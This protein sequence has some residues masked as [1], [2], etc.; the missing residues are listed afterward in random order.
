MNDCVISDDMGDDLLTCSSDTSRLE[1]DGYDQDLEEPT[2]TSVT[3][4]MASG[5]MLR[6]FAQF[7]GHQELA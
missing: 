5:E 3:E 6:Y 1:D 7:H 2:I 4:A